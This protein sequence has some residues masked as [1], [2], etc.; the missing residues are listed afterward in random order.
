MLTGFPRAVA[1]ASYS[2]APFVELDAGKLWSRITEAYVRI[3]AEFARNSQYPFQ[4]TWGNPTAVNM[5]RSVKYLFLTRWFPGLTSIRT[6]HIINIHEPLPQS[7][8][9]G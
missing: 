8:T 5:L 3:I 7:A 2:V 1:R 9:G 4:R 6:L